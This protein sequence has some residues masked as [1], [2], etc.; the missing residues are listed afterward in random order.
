MLHKSLKGCAIAGLIP[1][2]WILRRIKLRILL[3]FWRQQLARKNENPHR[4][5]KIHG[6]CHYYPCDYCV[7]YHTYGRV[8]NLPIFQRW[9]TIVDGNCSVWPECRVAFIN[10]RSIIHLDLL[11][12]TEACLD[13]QIHSVSCCKSK[14]ALITSSSRQRLN[15]KEI[16]N[17]PHKP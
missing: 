6:Y 14:L 4:D 15:T 3:I 13:N 1:V 9:Q 17:L 8:L 16:L 5:N 12:A 11:Y 10:Q 7:I 2:E